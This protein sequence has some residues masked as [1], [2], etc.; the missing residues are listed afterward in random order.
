MIRDL[1]RVV[2]KEGREK[3]I[4]GR[5]PWVQRGEVLRVE[6]K[7]EPGAEARLFAHNGDFLAVGTLHEGIRFPFRVFSLED[8]PLGVDFFRRR[9][10]E[11]LARRE[12]AAPDTNARRVVFAEADGLPGLIV[13]QYDDV[14]AVQVRQMGVERLK[15]AW[16]DAIV[17]VLKPRAIM[18][19][20]DM[21]S[22]RD[23]GLEPTSQPLV[24]DVPETVEI[25][26]SGLKF[27]VP[28]REGLKTGFYLDQRETRRQF[29][30]EV[31]PGMRVLDAFCY[32][33]AFSLHAARA[34]ADVVGVD[35][36]EGA[37]ETARA[38]AELNG[39]DVRF[40][41]ANAFDW[42]VDSAKMGP[43][44]DAV[45]LDPPAISK[46]RDRRD[47]LKWAVWRLVHSALPILKPGGRL[48]VCSCSYQLSLD[49]MIDTI[50]LAANDRG[51]AAY[52]D[53]VTLQAPDHPYLIQFPESLYLK[54]A[55]VRAA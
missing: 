52:V 41:L 32:T 47:S 33:G 14:L 21:E 30:A 51:R 48:V 38:N 31:T 5:Y 7:S 2:L 16:L 40:D 44:F 49:A 24:G 13:D 54:C 22:R 4:R 34:G 43:S 15:P 29:A 26:E 11:A 19:R 50:R 8:E 6:G 53:R 17:D 39:L 55:W 23:E 12:G 45:V 28:V 3:K 18:E 27:L 36:A 42:L 37:V 1:P 46:S 10:R 20:S 25:V 9:I 35:L